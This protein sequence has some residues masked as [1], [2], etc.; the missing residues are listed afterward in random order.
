M[1]TCVKVPLPMED[2]DACPFLSHLALQ[3]LWDVLQD[4]LLLH[5]S[6]Q[7]KNRPVELRK[8]NCTK[9][10]RIISETEPCLKFCPRRHRIEG[11]HDFKGG[12]LSSRASP[13]SFT[14]KSP[15]EN[16]AGPKLPSSI[17]K[18]YPRHPPEQEPRSPKHLLP[19]IRRSSAGTIEKGS[20]NVH[21]EKQR[22]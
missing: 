15:I 20:E 17:E 1:N 19:K 22:P 5:G 16:D 10:G 4:L 3:N 18:K 2:H 6:L 8:P 14:Q 13:V 11:L 12:L 9:A 21:Q 7:K